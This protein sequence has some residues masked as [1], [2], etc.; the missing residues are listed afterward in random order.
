LGHLL[1]KQ[2]LDCLVLI[3]QV[4]VQLLRLC[5]HLPLEGCNLLGMLPVVVMHLMFKALLLGK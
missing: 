1:L 3:F 4:A 2:R 5:L